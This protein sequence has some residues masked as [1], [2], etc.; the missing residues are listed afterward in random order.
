MH[1][2]PTS[3]FYSWITVS[4]LLGRDVVSNDVAALD[5]GG[6]S[7]QVCLLPGDATIAKKP[8]HVHEM[9]TIGNRTVTIYSH[10]YPRAGLLSA[11]ERLSEESS[12]GSNEK[13]TRDSP[14]VPSEN[15]GFERC[16]AVVKRV[17][18]D[19]NMFQLEEFQTREVYLMSYFFDAAVEAS[20]V[21][22]TDGAKPLRVGD[23]HKKAKNG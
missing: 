10:S 5:L 23:F 14:C 13:L 18:A 4:F 1:V 11:R 6:G 8:D 15:T 19:L 12:I 9:Q 22:E 3:G 2:R 17:V 7:T 21:P 20:L 16:Y